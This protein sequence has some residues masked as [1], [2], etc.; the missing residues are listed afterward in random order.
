M[1]CIHRADTLIIAQMFAIVNRGLRFADQERLSFVVR[2]GKSKR[3]NRLGLALGLLVRD[4][5]ANT[6]HRVR[7]V[8]DLRLVF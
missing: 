8:Y 7:A 1:R 2:A 4:V 6:K 3:A 5:S